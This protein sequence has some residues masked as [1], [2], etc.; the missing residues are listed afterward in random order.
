LR[1]HDITGSVFRGNKEKVQN[2]RENEA[3]HGRSSAS[4]RASKLTR[5][6]LS[7][8]LEDTVLPP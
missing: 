2:S 8:V 3:V 6:Y 4:R 1:H 5:G 7:R